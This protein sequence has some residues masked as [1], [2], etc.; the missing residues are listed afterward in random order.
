M[1]APARSLSLTRLL[2]VSQ[3]MKRT[4]LR[5]HTSASKNT[6]SGDDHFHPGDRPSIDLDWHRILDPEN[7]D[8]IAEDVRRRKGVGDIRQVHHLHGRYLS[9]PAEQR[10][11]ALEALTAAAIRLPNRTRPGWQGED[12]VAVRTVGQKPE[13]DFPLKDFRWRAEKLNMFRMDNLGLLTGSRTYVS[14]PV[15]AEGMRLGLCQLTEAALT[16][17]WILCRRGMICFG[18][19]CVIVYHNGTLSGLDRTAYRPPAPSGL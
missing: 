1:A 18:L 11:A 2:R 7:V 15:M 5:L 13:F 6:W 12:M 9:A 8:A 14:M 16:Q 19:F 10:A 4:A 17:M 3:R